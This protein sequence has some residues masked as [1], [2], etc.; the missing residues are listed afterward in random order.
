MLL[1][2]LWCGQAMLC[3]DAPE[4]PQGSPAEQVAGIRAKLE[5]ARAEHIR[6]LQKAATAADRDRLLREAPRPEPFA[7]LML[8]VADRHPNDPAALD[9]LLWVVG[10]TPASAMA[11]APNARAKAAIVKRHADSDR[12]A[13]FAVALSWSASAADE[14]ALRGLLARTHADRVRA[15]AM[16]ALALQLLAQAEMIELHQVRLE[17][18]SAEAERRRIRESLETDFGTET[19]LRLRSRNPKALTG[20]A[21]GLLQAIVAEPRF[22]AAPWPVSQGPLR[23]GDKAKREVE[24]LRQLSR[25]A[26]AP[27]TEG[28]DLS[29]KHVSLAAFR[30]KVVLLAFSG[31]W[32]KACRGL[33]PLARVLSRKHAARPFAVFVVSSDGSREEAKEAASGAE[34]LPWPTI[35]DGG[36]VHGPLA[37]LWNVEAWPLVVLIDQNGVIRH[38]FRGAPGPELLVPL[39]DRL[40]LE[41]ESKK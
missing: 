28:M 2:L 35:W 5:A 15:A 14:D 27:A 38:K 26:P 6:K 32:C 1:V 13:P 16:L 40:V 36:S 19:A 39:V 31:Q 41:A 9:A 21:E 10:N 22:A 34:G 7:D 29:G 8:Q 17:A 25:G 11:G 30:G 12:L 18:A 3:K 33:H 23:L 20:E 37:T 24:A 4:L